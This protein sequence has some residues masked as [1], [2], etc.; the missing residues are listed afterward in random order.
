[1]E[2]VVRMFQTW[3][4]AEAADALEDMRMSGEQRISIILELQE[5]MFP[6]A[7]QQ[8]FERV[9]RITQLESR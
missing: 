2:E 8:G 6:N 4:D 3:E 5:R 1:M 7:S 9:Y